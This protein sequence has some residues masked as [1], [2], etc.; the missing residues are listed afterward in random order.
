MERDWP[1]SWVR[2]DAH[3]ET[4]AVTRLD[5]LINIRYTK[6]IFHASLLHIP[7]SR[8]PLIS[9]Q[10]QNCTIKS[11]KHLFTKSIFTVQDTTV[12]LALV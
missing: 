9:I 11:R 7:T 3:P 10:N 12:A 5:Y 8:R 2:L 4:Q 6:H 1:L